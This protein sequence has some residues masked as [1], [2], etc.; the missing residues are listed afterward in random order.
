MAA[1]LSSHWGESISPVCSDKGLGN[2][3]SSQEWPSSPL[4][5]SAGPAP[6]QGG[7]YTDMDTRA[8]DP[9]GLCPTV[10]GGPKRGHAGEAAGGVKSSRQWGSGMKPG[11]GQ[12]QAPSTLRM[13]AQ[14]GWTAAEALSSGGRG[15]EGTP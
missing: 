4:P 13:D 3:T 6:T 15:E 5:Y 11:S 12:V 2:V 9:Q 10:C 8:R 7:G 14:A 1:Y